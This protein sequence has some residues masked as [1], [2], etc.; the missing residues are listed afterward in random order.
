MDTVQVKGIADDKTEKEVLLDIERYNNIK[1]KISI[2]IKGNTIK[3]VKY[4]HKGIEVYINVNNLEPK[5]KGDKYQISKELESEIE[6]EIGY[7]LGIERL[8]QAYW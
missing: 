3:G 5:L 8:L 7:Y 6:Y 4:E 1:K 2:W